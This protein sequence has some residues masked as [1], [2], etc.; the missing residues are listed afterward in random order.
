MRLFKIAA[1]AAVVGFMVATAANAETADITTCLKRGDEVKAALA[2][3]SGSA[4]YQDAQKERRYGLEYCNNNFF[5]Q[6]LSHY[7]RALK[8]LGVSDK[9]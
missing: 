7:D 1:G 5:A 4:N 9:G 8:L 2:D 6:G 3:K